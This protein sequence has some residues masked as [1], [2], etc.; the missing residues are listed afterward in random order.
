MSKKIISIID[1]NVLAIPIQECFD[2]MVDLS[3]QKTIFLG[4]FPEI[5]NNKDY[6]KVRAKIYEKLLTAQKNLPS[7]LR[8][9]LYEGYRSLQLQEQ[10]FNQRYH[11]S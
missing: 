5:P 7:P 6:T 11:I 4:E 9:C 2:A 10:L 8:F 3:E 1:P